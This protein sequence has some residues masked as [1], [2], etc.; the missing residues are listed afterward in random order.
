[1]KRH[2]RRRRNGV[3]VALIGNKHGENGGGREEKP[4]AAC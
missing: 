2:Q 1:M 3:T 4:A